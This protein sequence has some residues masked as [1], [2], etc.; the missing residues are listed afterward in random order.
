MLTIRLHKF[1]LIQDRFCFLLIRRHYKLE[2]LGHTNSV[3]SM[4]EWNAHQ[5]ASQIQTSFFFVTDSSVINSAIV[6]INLDC[7][8]YEIFVYIVPVLLSAL[9]G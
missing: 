8:T 9:Y 2:F 1:K 4:I 7:N 3:H 6:A 5:Q